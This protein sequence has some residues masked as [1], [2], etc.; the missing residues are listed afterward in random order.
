[1]HY[2]LRIVRGAVCAGLM[3]ASLIIVLPENAVAQSAPQ[4][5][6]VE[7]NGVKLNYLIAGTGD[8]VVLL[9]GFLGDKPA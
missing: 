3:A 2:F 4:S 7:V 5:R 6:S 9:H 1:M 8:P